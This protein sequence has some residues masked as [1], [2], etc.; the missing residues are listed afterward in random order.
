MNLSSLNVSDIN[1]NDLQ[2]ILNGT[3]GMRNTQL[4]ARKGELEITTTSFNI[5]T[6]SNLPIVFKITNTERMKLTPTELTLNC[7][8]SQGQN[9]SANI[10]NLTSNVLIGND[11]HTS[12]LNA[13][14]I[15]VSDLVLQVI[16]TTTIN[17][18]YLNSS[19]C[20]I[21]EG[22]FSDINGS[23]GNISECIIRTLTGH[24]ATY[25]NLNSTLFNTCDITC[26]D[27]TLEEN[28]IMKLETSIGSIRGQLTANSTKFS[29]GSSSGQYTTLTNANNEIVNIYDNRVNMNVSLNVSGKVNSSNFTVNN[30]INELSIDTNTN[31]FN[32]YSNG[33]PIHFNVN[34]NPFTT[35][36]MEMTQTKNLML[37]DLEMDN[38]VEANISNL[39]ASTISVSTFNITQT[40][41]TNLNASTANTS[42]IN[43][44]SGFIALDATREVDAAGGG[45]FIQLQK[46]HATG[47]TPDTAWRFGPSGASNAF[48]HFCIEKSNS[49]NGDFFSLNEA[50]STTIEMFVNKNKLNFNDSGSFSL[51]KPSS[52]GTAPFG[53]QFQ[54][55]ANGVFNLMGYS[56]GQ[57]YLRGTGSQYGYFRYG[58]FTPVSDD[59]LKHNETPIKTGLNAIRKLN[60]VSYDLTHNIFEPNNTEYQQ[61]LIAQE[62]YEIEEFK[63]AVVEGEWCDLSGDEIPLDNAGID[64]S[65]NRYYKPWKLTYEHR[66]IIVNLIQAVQDLDEKQTK[67]NE[68]INNLE[69]KVNDLEAE[70]EILKG[71]IQ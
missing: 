5:S 33:L 10:S 19:Y 66:S 56:S 14:I 31:E 9:Y 41:F 69:T 58:G 49:N 67:Q 45:C 13:S 32:I 26:D 70:N 61:G 20:N 40:S 3:F 59:L 21:C 27:F 44:S 16:D 18:R 62:V 28:G 71:L 29:I 2:I 15:N 7:N 25:D 6:S 24:V 46:S 43:I 34:T 8:L 64:I 35:N 36:N 11:I 68:K 48:N 47:T 63:E 53:F 42:M 39:N 23:D 65:N 1:V 52:A 60:P 54:V 4:P 55:E 50:S 12:T 57:I 51:I 17:T 37:K 30:N 38:T 22:N